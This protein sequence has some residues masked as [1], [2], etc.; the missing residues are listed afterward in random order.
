MWRSVSG[1]LYVYHK[2]SFIR[3]CAISLASFQK[4][5]PGL[6]KAAQRWADRCLG[7]VHDNATGLYLDGFGQSG[8][9]IFISTGRTLWWDII[10]S[11]LLLVSEFA[12]PVGIFAQVQ[13]GGTRARLYFAG[14]CGV[15]PRDGGAVNRLIAGSV[16]YAEKLS[17]RENRRPRVRQRAGATSPV[18]S[19]QRRDANFSP[20]RDSRLLEWGAPSETSHV[21]FEVGLVETA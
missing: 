19:T 11:C 7:L 9:N 10:K 2:V 1:T 17:P 5:H 4:W 20:L 8:Q 12:L 13:L 6:A 3:P 18:R 14:I 15:R 16:I 21:K